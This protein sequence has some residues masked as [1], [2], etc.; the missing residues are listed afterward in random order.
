MTNRKAPMTIA[1]ADAAGI[2]VAVYASASIAQLVSDVRSS[3]ARR[4]KSSSKAKR[5]TIERRAIRA[6]KYGA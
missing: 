5:I 4:G 6:I 2:D 3:S 1:E